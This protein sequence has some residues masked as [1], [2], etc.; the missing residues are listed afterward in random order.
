[1]WLPPPPQ[2]S[3]F[4]LCAPICHEY[5]PPNKLQLSWKKCDVLIFDAA[6]DCGC[7]LA[8]QFSCQVHWPIRASRWLEKETQWSEWARETGNGCCSE[9]SPNLF[10]GR[11]KNKNNNDNDNNH[12]NN[13]NDNGVSIDL[14]DRAS[15]NYGPGGDCVGWMTS[16]SN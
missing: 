5:L 6:A 3:T 4:P 11:N 9:E 16:H 8:G 7:R 2:L 13:Y 14:L 12:N 10:R 15:A 1:M